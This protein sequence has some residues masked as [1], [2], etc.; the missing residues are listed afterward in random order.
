MPGEK[1]LKF[2]KIPY[3]NGSTGKVHARTMEAHVAGV[4]VDQA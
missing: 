1:P 3:K 2:L 4:A